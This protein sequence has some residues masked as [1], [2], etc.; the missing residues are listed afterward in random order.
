[1]ALLK[2]LIGEH[3]TIVL[4]LDPTPRWVKA[5]AVQLEQVLLNLAVNARDAMP[6][7][8]T[9]TIDTSQVFPEEVWGPTHEARATRTCCAAAR[10]RHGNRHRPGHEGEDL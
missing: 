5:D 1:M 6:H 2:S 7:G 8:G 10:P 4:Q 3:V 9:L